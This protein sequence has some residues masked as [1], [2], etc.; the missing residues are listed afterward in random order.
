MAFPQITHCLVCEDIRPEPHEKMS[1]LGFYGVAP[2]ASIVFLGP[3]DLPM[4][5][6]AFLFLADEP[7]AQGKFTIAVKILG[8]DHNVIAE[9]PPVQLQ[10][11]THLGTQ[12]MQVAAQLQQVRFPKAGAYAVVL[13]VDGVE[14]YKGGLS[15]RRGGEQAASP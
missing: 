13:M 7:P 14:H 3:F 5:R 12:R 2:S 10:A 15:V 6:L 11:P 1:I 8:E 9:T 4:D